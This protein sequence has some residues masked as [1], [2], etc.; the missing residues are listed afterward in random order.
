MYGQWRTGAPAL[1]V[2]TPPILHLNQPKESPIC[3]EH[4]RCLFVFAV[5]L[6]RFCTGRQAKELFNYWQKPTQ[7]RLK[8]GEKRAKNKGISVLF[9]LFSPFLFFMLWHKSTACFVEALFVHGGESHHLFFC[10]AHLFVCWESDALVLSLCANDTRRNES[11]V[12]GRLIN[13]GTLVLGAEQGA[14]IFCVRLG[15]MRA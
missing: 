2:L 14:H 12:Q 4:T 3:I 7:T 5:L 10:S 8:K 1:P 11:T 15:S 13:D 6:N 9:V